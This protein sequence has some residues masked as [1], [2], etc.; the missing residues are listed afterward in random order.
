M[1]PVGLDRHRHV[2]GV[3]PHRHVELEV[4]GDLD[5]QGRRCAKV[6]SPVV[7]STDQPESCSTPSRYTFTVPATGLVMVRTSITLPD[8]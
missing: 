6:T 3:E 5:P 7:V 2:V 1:Q 8:G 4:G